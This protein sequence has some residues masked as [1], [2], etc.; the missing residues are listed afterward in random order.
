MVD[1]NGKPFAKRINPIGE[2]DEE[3]REDAN[4]NVGS[5]SGPALNW[6]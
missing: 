6:F 3:P 5:I 1:A 2:D 4:Q